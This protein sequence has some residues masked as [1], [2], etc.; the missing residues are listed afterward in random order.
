MPSLDAGVWQANSEEDG[1]LNVYR[2]HLYLRRD[3][4]SFSTLMHFPD[5]AFRPPDKHPQVLLYFLKNW[6]KGEMVKE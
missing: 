3:S 2:A 4:P 6:V 1:V 5:P